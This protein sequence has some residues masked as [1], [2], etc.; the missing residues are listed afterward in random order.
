M[1]P[2]SKPPRGSWWHRLRLSPPFAGSR[3]A[4]FRPA[5]APPARFSGP[6]IPKDRR[7]AITA[8]A[9]G[10]LAQFRAWIDHIARQYP[11]RL[12]VIVFALI[13]ALVTALLCLPIS[14][15]ARVVPPFVDALFTATTSVCV[16]GLTTVDM[17]T[18]WS[19][20][21]Q[22]VVMIGISIGGLGVMTLASILGFAVSRHIGLTQ[23]MLAASETK[24]SSLGQV[25]S[26]LKAVVFTA[27]GVDVLLFICFLPRFLSLNLPVGKAAW[28]ALFMAVSTFNNAG[29]IILPDGLAPH[30]TDLS[31]I[32][33]VI[34]GT[35]MGAIGFPAFMDL[36][37]HWFE[38]RRLS[39]HTKITLTTYLSLAVI[40]ALLVGASEWN[41]PETYGQ[42]SAMQRIPHALLSGVNTR[43][44][45]ISFID[46]GQMHKGTWFIQDILMFIGGGSASTAG[47]IKVTTIAVLS[48]AV[49]AEARGDRD[50]EAFGRRIPY[51]TVRLAI[52]VSLI[53]TFL[54]AVAVLIL[55]TVTPYSLDVVLFESISA[56]GTVGLSTGITPELPAAGKYVLIGLMY[57]GRTGTMTVAAALALRQRR[58]V[59]RMSVEQPIIG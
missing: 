40:G 1:A 42:L 57:L 43:S 53:G 49:L 31:I 13:I 41:N 3:N 23:R 7:V 27:V 22:F 34:I 56:F 59:I 15:R 26:L 28:H 20:F 45:G 39:L 5:T 11:T 29:L 50:I 32:V 2:K 38:P 12:A 8:S 25:G 21:G 37:R 54:V 51:T 18:Y 33:P 46:V 55:L 44:S 48:L 52:A 58:R 24:T 16:T 14:T 36:R 30:A 19:T 4:H 6:S 10:R 17:S 9:P 35:A 47:G